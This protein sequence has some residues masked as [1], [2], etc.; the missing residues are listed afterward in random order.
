MMADEIP[1]IRDYMPGPRVAS[2]YNERLDRAE[3]YLR[4]AYKSLAIV[5][6]LTRPRDAARRTF[7]QAEA[8]RYLAIYDKIMAEDAG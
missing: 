7:E 2:G 6:Q 5:E 3:T 4:L 8:E 1:S